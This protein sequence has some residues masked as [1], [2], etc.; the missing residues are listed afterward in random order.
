VSF[1]QKKASAVLAA[2]VC[3]AVSE[4]AAVAQ[5]PLAH[6][7]WDWQTATPESQGMSSEKLD[8]LRD[9]LA[10]EHTQAF[11]VV[12][13]DKIV[14]EWYAKDTS[15]STKLGT[16]SL[17]KALVGGMSAAVA[18]TDG[19]IQLD[20][21][22]AKYV[23]QWQ[24]DPR[25][26]QITLRQLGS[27]TSGME[28][29]ESNGQPHDK[30]TGWR[31]TFWSQ[32]P[33]PN[34]P[35]TLARDQAPILYEPGTSIH[36]SNPGI[37]MLVYAITSA[38]RDAPEKDVRTLLRDRLMRPIGVADQDWSVGYGKTFNVDGLP[39]VPDWGGGSFTARA[40]ARIGRLILHEGNW[41]GKQVLSKSAVAQATQNAGLPGGCGMGW[42]TNGLGRY[43]YLPK[44]AVWGAGAGDRVVL[45]IPSLQLI[46]VRSGQNLPGAPSFA[47]VQEKKLDVLQR[48]H[49]HRAKNFFGPLVETI[50]DKRSAFLSP[51]PPSEIITQIKWAPANTVIRQARDSDNWPMAWGDDDHQYT[52]YGDGTGFDPKVPDKLS[53]GFARIEGGPAHFSGSNIRSP[54]GETKGNGKAGKKAS[55][56]L[57]VDGVLYAWIRNAGN[58]QL[59][60]STDHGRTWSWSDW[61]FTTSF[62]Y[63]TFLEFGRNYAGARDDYVYVYS[64]D[65]DSAYAPADRMI[66]ARVPRNRIKDQAAY[67][68]CTGAAENREA[69]WNKEIGKRGGVF[70]N[71]GK[72]YRCTVS[73]NAGLRRYLLCQAGADRNV[74]AGFGVFDASEPWGP[75]TTICYVPRWDVDPGETASFPTKWMSTDGCKLHLVYS[76]GDSFNVRRAELTVQRTHASANR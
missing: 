37:G 53:L 34:D 11:L 54:S 14:Y 24:N 10:R 20:D 18:L 12:R 32:Q 33:P 67:E 2:L 6:S 47:K 30:L 40:M 75:W 8:R 5:A 52:A 42:W 65:S 9:W 44:D 27:H 62:G 21:K 45:V 28:D 15:P 56:M 43:D 16:A 69:G 64:P 63:P 59:A 57:M 38:L 31:G 17:A 36:Y 25:K 39:L 58:A 29:A 70:V 22:A 48:F 51:Y 74:N 50:T 41:E 13:N 60:W 76:G 66:L 19:R 73:Y 35:F 4:T 26:S 61:K 49:D 72:C 55:G 68:F 3:L 71:P 46:M 7:A 1:L 23:L